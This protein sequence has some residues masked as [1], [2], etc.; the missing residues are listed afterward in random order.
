MPIKKAVWR[1]Q[2]NLWETVRL[3][4]RNEP[5]EE[6]ARDFKMERGKPAQSGQPAVDR[7]GGDL[8]NAFDRQKDFGSDGDVP[9]KDAAIYY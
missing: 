6:K 1:D 9:L 7:A 8:A 5:N 2:Q 3:K 4:T